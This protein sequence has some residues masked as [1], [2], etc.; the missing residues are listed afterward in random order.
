MVLLQEEVKEKL[1]FGLMLIY[2]ARKEKYVPW[3]LNA[4]DGLLCMDLH[5]M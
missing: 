4:A 1:A 2:L 3:A 5:L